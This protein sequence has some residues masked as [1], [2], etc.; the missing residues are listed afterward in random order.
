MYFLI[1]ISFFRCSR[2][3]LIDVMTLIKVANKYFFFETIIKNT[4]NKAFLHKEK[5][6]IS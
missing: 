2:I 3:L 4:L 6:K 5:G 1:G